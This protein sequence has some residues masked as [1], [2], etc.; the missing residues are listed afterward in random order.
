M[1]I[2]PKV[3][4][5][6]M[7]G[8][9]GQNAKSLMKITNQEII[10]ED[11]GLYARVYV[12]PSKRLSKLLSIDREIL[13]LLT[14]FRDQQ[15]RTI[16]TARKI[17]D[18][19]AGRLESTIAI[20]VHPDVNGNLKLKKW[21]REH[22]ISVLPIYVPDQ[23]PDEELL[24]KI[25]CRELF[26]HD[27]FDVTGPVSDDNQ[28]YGRRTEAQDLAR[29]LQKGQI[30]ACLGIRKI[31]KTSIINRIISVIRTYHDC[32]SVMVDCSKDQIWSM[33]ASQ[34]LTAL[35]DAVSSALKAPSR[36][37]G[38]ETVQDK[39][40]IVKSSEKLLAAV[41]SSSL[42][43]IM[44]FDE[45]DYITPGTGTGHHWKDDFNVFW[46]NLRAIYQEAAR[47][48]KKLSI[49]VSGVSSKWF[50]V[51]TING[52][53]NAALA[54]V[55]EEYLSPLPRG[56]SIPMIKNMARTSGLQFDD[57]IANTIAGVCSDNPFWIRKACSYIHRQIDTSNRP[58]RPDDSLISS[59]LQKF[60]E[61]E[62]STLSQVALRHLFRVYPELEEV[63]IQCYSSSGAKS[64]AVFV[65]VLERY[66]VISK[67]EKSY[68]ISGEMMKEGLKLYLDQK[69][70]APVVVDHKKS[71]S[72]ET[73]K[74]AIETLDEWA[75]ELALI[76]KRR[77]VLEKKLR[78][79][80]L[81]F[82]RY[83]SL[84]AKQKGTLVNRVLKVVEEQRRTKYA[85]FPAEEIIEKYLWSD[86]T[87]LVE[88]E[89]ALFE[90]IFG[91]KKE[92]TL[93]CS[94]INE[95]FDAHAKAAD[96]ADL[97]LYRRSLKWMEDNLTAI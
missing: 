50:C 69:Q 80:V 21:G 72:L 76:N 83:D 4:L 35:A 31:G 64:P 74:I 71:S 44:F 17:I 92:F 1:Q 61:S 63:A 90:K 52:I 20:I 40:G 24:E 11:K 30:R 68:Q 46:R 53:E 81:N 39:P 86:L 16:K 73:G 94:V 18:G 28:F 38:L 32:Y 51:E 25:L 79:I 7:M 47:S 42:P 22:G 10:E 85:Q 87:K 97:A 33:N 23:F 82:I 41:E 75:D 95:R 49:L 67:K 15:A 36:Y 70:T 2:Q 77:N 96:M 27:P 45:V 34:L 37:S 13:V 26:S 48:E 84:Q 89:W 56:A 6:G 8:E 65:T 60:V 29:Q 9:L 55:P 14:N 43:V 5:E 88:K 91:D 3:I 78:S 59:L 54:F 58:L 57:S 19:A 62:G 12:K 93:N 66:G